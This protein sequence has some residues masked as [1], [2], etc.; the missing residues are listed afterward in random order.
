MVVVSVVIPAKNEQLNLP[1]LVQEVHQMLRSNNIA[2][3]I[4]VVDDASTDATQSILLQLKQNIAPLRVLSHQQSCGQSGA[5]RTGILAAQG[6]VIATLDGD[7]QNDPSF[8]PHMLQVLE[9]DNAVTLVAGQRVVRHDTAVKAVTSKLANAVRSALLGDGIRDT[10]CGLK[11]FYRDTFLALPYFD[12]MH[13]YLPALVL[14]EGQKIATADVGHR[15]RGGG[16]SNY[17]T[18]DR[19]LVALVDLPAVLWLKRRR[20]LP[21]AV[22]EL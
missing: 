2:G 16:R 6:R 15:P 10:G 19:L 22:K 3:E 17:G 7:G 18:I 11:V 4:I 1:I 8:I 20:K 21:G 9:Q 12:H 14:R 13:R 5:L